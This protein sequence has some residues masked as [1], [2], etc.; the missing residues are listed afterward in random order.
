VV[1]AL[2]SDPLERGLDFSTPWLY[3]LDAGKALHAAVRRH[4]GDAAFIQCCQGYC[5][6]W[7][8]S[9]TS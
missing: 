2:L 9:I 1:G 3:V 5:E 4:A 7:S 6:R 8:G